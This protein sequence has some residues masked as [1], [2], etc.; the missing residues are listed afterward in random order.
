MSVFGVIL[1]E[2]F[3]SFFHI[4]TEYVERRSQS[5]CGKMRTRITPNTDTF[6]AVYMLVVPFLRRAEA[7]TIE[8]YR[9][10]NTYIR[11]ILHSKEA[12]GLQ[13]LNKWEPSFSLS[14]EVS[15]KPTCKRY[16]QNLSSLILKFNFGTC[17]SFKNWI[18]VFQQK[19][20]NKLT[21]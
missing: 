17:M 4:R 6:Y 16:L 5:E 12:Y 11:R 3:P 15:L 18:I 1:A 8:Q 14:L 13:G 21:N 7:K 20:I 9:K 19:I 10:A 2:I